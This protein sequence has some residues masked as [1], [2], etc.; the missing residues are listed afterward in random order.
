MQE[1]WTHSTNLI[2]SALAAG[3][4]QS[5]LTCSFQLEDMVVLHMVLPLAPRIPVIFL[6]TGY[7][8]PEVY[9]YRDAMA[10]AWNI[11]L[12]NVEPSLSVAEQEAQFGVLYRTEPDR[13]CRL[14]KVEPLM[15]ALEPFDLWL[16]GLRREQSP[17]RANL[18][19]EETQRLPSGKTIRKINP[20]AE[21][22]WTDVT[23]YA[24]AHDI[25]P[26]PLYQ[27]G[28]TSIG[29]APCTTLPQDPSNP[30]SGRWGGRKL[31]CGIHTF[32]A[33]R[34]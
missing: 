34:S 25:S 2:E 11:N 5:V 9:A 6:D 19:I 28:Y 3:R 12:V 15:R 31:E 10:R 7:H 1:L 4:S 24:L 18:Q 27:Q 23:A 30:R 8:F 33:T 21:W 16:T 29:C 14:R 22:T 32:G 17:S 20:L 13:C 26:L